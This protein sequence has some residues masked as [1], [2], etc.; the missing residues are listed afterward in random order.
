MELNIVTLNSDLFHN[1][2]KTHSS[3]MMS[4]YKCSYISVYKISTVPNI[5]GSA[6]TLRCFWR[7]D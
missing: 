1:L 7:V 5:R 3:G 6:Q 4:I 2:D